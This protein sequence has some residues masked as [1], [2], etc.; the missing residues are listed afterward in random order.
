MDQGIGPANPG[1]LSGVVLLRAIDV[2]GTRIVV[3]AVRASTGSCF[4]VGTVDLRA[5]TV[6]ASEGA[7]ADRRGD[8][9]NPCKHEDGK[10]SSHR[11]TVT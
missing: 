6:M 5:I 11:A 9:E 2:L 3:A 4:A 7:Q 8:E 1:G 10:Y